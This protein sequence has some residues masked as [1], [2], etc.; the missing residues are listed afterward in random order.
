MES[1]DWLVIGVYFASLGLLAYVVTR[2]SKTDAG[3]YFLAGKSLGWFVVG[4]SIFASNIGSEHLVGL[5]GSGVE[6]GITMAH[7]ELHAWCLLILGWFLVPVY[8]NTQVYTMPEF[9]E[10]R[11]SATSR[12]ILSIVSLIAYVVAKISVGLYAG[13]VVFSV[14]LPDVTFLGLDSFWAGSLCVLFITGL[15]TT[16]G[17]FK[18]VAYTEAFQTVVLILGSVIVTVYGLIEIGGWGQLVSTV[19]EENFNLWK[20]IVPEGIES[21]WLPI[22]EN[23]SN[24]DI[25]KIAWY[26]SIPGHFP[27]IGML[28]CAPIIGMWYWCTDQYIVQRTLGAKNIEEARRGT[29]FAG[30]LKLLPVFI[31][32][33]PG[34]ICG[35]LVLKAQESAEYDSQIHEEM[36]SDLNDEVVDGSKAFPVLVKLILPS[37]LRGL[38]VAGL[39]SALMSSLAGVFSSCSTL[40]AMDVYPLFNKHANEEQKV[41]V[42]KLVTLSLVF[43]G[44]AWLPIIRNS[45]GLYLYLQSIQGYLAPPIFAVFFFGVFW[46]RL[47]A[48]GCTCALIVGML[49]GI[50]R[51]VIDTPSKIY[52]TFEYQENSILWIISKI[53]FQ[54]FSLIIFAVSTIT[55]VVVSYATKKQESDSINDTVFKWS[56]YNSVD[57]RSTS[58]RLADFIATVLLLLLI[59]VIYVLF[60]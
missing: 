19:G 58:R 36:L 40:F 5:A 34:I 7:Y 57:S 23:D 59:V 12:Y 51:L 60:S 49:M 26:F 50:L 27:W 3:E 6:N 9:L 29:I 25:S 28:F 37:G 22:E 42:G 30:Y 35:G 52:P 31:F 55:L 48:K 21:S 43:L 11:F 1:L 17:G 10:K 47:N 16:L 8:L 15:Y 44:L 54:Y 46:K 24:G 38:V 39:L 13:G 45:Q 14:L 2:K 33:M 53:Y 4:T 20:P 18:A 32:I 56:V 41:R